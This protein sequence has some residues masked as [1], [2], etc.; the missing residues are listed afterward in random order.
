MQ[1]AR[2]LPIDGLYLQSADLINSYSLIQKLL[3]VKKK[4]IKYIQIA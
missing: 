2:V 1:V 3:T 4:E